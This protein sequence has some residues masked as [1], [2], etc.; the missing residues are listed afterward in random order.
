MEGIMF[1]RPAA[2][3]TTPTRRKLAHGIG[4]VGLVVALVIAV[5]AAILAATASCGC[6]SPADLIVLNYAHEDATV[7][8]QG[9]GLL[10][11]PILGISGSATASA[12]ATFSQTL[13]PGSVDVS[14][15]AGSDGQTVRVTV[16]DGEARSGHVA[17]LVIAADGH[18]AGP[19]DGAP[20]GGYPRDPLCN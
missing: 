14:I 18:I 17:T 12:C 1:E 15:R 10:G 3:T 8:W 4:F 16:P 13:K 11:A 9:A 6:A 2:S 5:P 19:N 7:S 20:A